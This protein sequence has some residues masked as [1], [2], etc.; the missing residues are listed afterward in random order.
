VCQHDGTFDHLLVPLDLSATAD[1]ALP[2]VGGIA[3]AI[4]LPVE[5]LT[6]S[7]PFSDVRADR[8]ALDERLVEAGPRVSARLVPSSDVVTAIAEVGRE[9]R[10]LICMSTHGRGVFGRNV[11][12]SVA[13][14]VLATSPRPIV[15]VGPMVDVND[16]GR[17]RSILFGTDGFL[18]VGPDDTIVWLA[19]QLRATVHVVTVEET[20]GVIVPGSILTGLA[21]VEH[22][23]GLC[24]SLA[25]F[26]VDARPTV[27]R[28][29]HPA[30]GLC[31][32]AARLPS[33]LAVM[34]GRRSGLA[35]RLGL[36]S[37]SGAV[38]RDGVA[39]VIIVPRSRA[40]GDQAT[41]GGD[42]SA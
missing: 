19:R 29:D 3:T 1:R 30:E 40:A 10:A 39:P 38:V 14:D 2:V 32:V 11:V 17:P 16:Y 23:D 4:D 8:R 36:G 31:A 42:G 20:P 27:I 18:T 12:G 41:T 9:G 25:Q 21:L 22:V 7:S 37:V 5:L 13:H 33:P 28:E 6:V 15:L 34:A 26:G 35:G 24:A